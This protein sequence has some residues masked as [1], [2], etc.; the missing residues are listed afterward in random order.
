MSPLISVLH[1]GA[2]ISFSVSWKR[3][4]TH[5]WLFKLEFLQG[6]EHWK[7]LFCCLVDVTT[8]LADHKSNCRKVS[9]MIHQVLAVHLQSFLTSP[10]TD[11][12]NIRLVT[13]WSAVTSMSHIL[14]QILLPTI[15]L[16]FCDPW[17]LKL[18][19]GTQN[20][21]SVHWIMPDWIHT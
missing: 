16:W 21:K 8:L 19:T 14:S 1:P 18:S 10:L 5:E 4:F 6:N 3:Y 20:H 17:E 9:I 13:R 2:V 7:L 11:V 12:F 15:S